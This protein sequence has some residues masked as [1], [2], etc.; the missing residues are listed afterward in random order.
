MFYLKQSWWKD[1]QENSEQL[2]LQ[3]LS[4][5]VASQYRYEGIAR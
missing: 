1:E 5:G 4:N 3:D 2:F